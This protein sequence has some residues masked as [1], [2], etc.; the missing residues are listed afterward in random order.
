MRHMF[1]IIKLDIVDSFE[2]AFNMGKP[3]SDDDIDVV[4][5][6]WA[7]C[8]MEYRQRRVDDSGDTFF[9]W[10]SRRDSMTTAS[11]CYVFD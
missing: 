11:G 10:L 1:E 9:G 8:F 6:Q 4:R 7:E 2:K 3:Y 5:R